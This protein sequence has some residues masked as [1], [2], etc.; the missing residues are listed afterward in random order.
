M[1]KY[2]L[3]AI[4]FLCVFCSNN[5]DKP[6]QQEPEVPGSSTNNP[7]ATVTAAPIRA[8]SFNIRYENTGDGE[9]VWANRR[10]RVADAINFYDVDVL[11]TQE[12]LNSQLEDLKKRLPDYS[13][14]GVGREDGKTKG[15]YSALWYKPSRFTVSRSG[16]FWLSETPDQ[17]SKGWDAACERIA[18]WAILYDTQTKKEI[19]VLNTHL[20]HVGEKA[21][22]NGVKMVLDKVTELSS[23]RPV[24]VTGDFN[25]APESNVIRSLTDGGLTHTRDVAGT[26]YGPDWSWHDWQGYNY[27]GKSLIDYV[28]VKNGFDVKSYGVCAETNNG[29]YL[30]DHCP[31]LVTLNYK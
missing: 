5:T 8:M 3:L 11:G 9:N 12:V 23:G 4:P 27:G 6:Q 15:E 17:P 2:L 31:V 26:V 20:D 25:S 19:F 1:K 16:N 10:D 30:S 29:K 18:T 22:A 21:R 13:V 24:I 14:I 28:F 7:A